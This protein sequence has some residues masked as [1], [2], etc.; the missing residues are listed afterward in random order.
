[1]GLIAAALLQSGCGPEVEGAP[2]AIEAVFTRPGVLEI[3]NARAIDRIEVR[4][5]SGRPVAV[6]R[7]F[8]REVFEVRFDWKAKGRYRLIANRGEQLAVTAPVKKPSFALRIHAP[9]GQNVH[10]YLLGSKRL[11]GRNETIPLLAEPG[12]SVDLL[13]EIEKLT[14]AATSPLALSI[15]PLQP[16]PR[17]PAVDP[18]VREEAI[19]LGFEFDKRVWQAAIRL[20][21]T[22]P[23]ASAAVALSGAGIDYRVQL[24]VSRR[25]IRAG[26]LKL[27]AWEMP[28]DE[29][30][31]FQPGRRPDQV[32]LPNPV[33]NRIA[34][35]FNVQ[36]E[37]VN[38]Y[39]PFV[40]E[41]LDFEN[42]GK[43]PVNLLL[44]SQVVDPQSGEQ[45]EYFT[46]PDFSLSGTAK[47]VMG[48]CRVPAGAR[49]SCVLP[50]FVQPKTPAGTYR[51]QIEVYAMGTDTALKTLRAPVHVLRSHLAFSAWMVV[52]VLVSFGWLLAVV[53]FYRRL[54]TSFGVRLLTLLSLLGSL[55]F[56]LHFGGT[57]L[58]SISYAVL[59]PFNC[60]VGGLFTEVLTYLLVT[61]VLYL[62]PR[63]GAMTIAGIVSYLMGGILFGSFG[64]TDILFTGSTIAFRELCLLGFGVTRIRPPDHYRPP[65]VRT[66]LA[67]GLADAASTFS[68]LTLHSVFY[69]L[70]FADW[71]IALQVVV[72]GFLYTVIGVYLGRSL[73]I[74]LRKVHP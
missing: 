20:G 61:A 16:P 30:G 52:I 59:G 5:Q 43:Q 56:C 13:V 67:L 70:F 50:I 33:W 36:A 44:K 1:M 22:L 9:L 27:A 23:E 57:L 3:R 12:E 46:A 74:G 11:R 26:N 19:S 48:Y 47:L 71:Y 8:G 32:A 73:G 4:E 17:G 37:Q 65:L 49:K 14:D 24:A 51:R 55:Q 64:L 18:E 34:A 72:T 38:Y 10:E 6:A 28:C 66:M 39:E 68:S 45:A 62:V 41:R 58:T 35:L 7:G 63:V 2:P 21:E 15:L 29:Q 42:R 25:D 60:L 53:L 31:L 54:V 40:H 69:R